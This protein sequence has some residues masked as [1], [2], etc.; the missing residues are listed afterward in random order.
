MVLGVCS[1][2][3]SCSHTAGV[4]DCDLGHDGHAVPAL[5][6]PA[7]PVLRPQPVQEMP[8]VYEKLPKP[9]ER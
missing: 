5:V 7:G 2:T 9:A 8:G 6:A 4:C 3:V 1:M